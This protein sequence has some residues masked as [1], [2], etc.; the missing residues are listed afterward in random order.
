MRGAADTAI[1]WE[2]PD[3]VQRKTPV[4]I[5]VHRTPRAGSSFVVQNHGPATARRAARSRRRFTACI[6]RR[7]APGLTVVSA[8]PAKTD[9]QHWTR[10][11]LLGQAGSGRTGRLHGN[12][13][14][15]GGVSGAH[16]PP[17]REHRGVEDYHA[18]RYAAPRKLAKPMSSA[19]A[20][21][22]PVALVAR[23][24]ARGTAAA[25]PA[26]RLSSKAAVG[27]TLP[28]RPV[29]RKP[30]PARPFVPR[31]ALAGAHDR[32]SVVTLWQLD[33]AFLPPDADA[34][35]HRVVSTNLLNRTTGRLCVGRRVST[36]RLRLSVFTSSRAPRAR[37]PLDTMASQ[38]DAR[39]RRTPLRVIADSTRTPS[40][41]G[42]V[43]PTVQISFACIGRAAVRDRALAYALRRD[44][45][46]PANGA[47]RPFRV[48]AAHVVCRHVVRP[49]PRLSTRRR[50][51]H[52]VP[53][54][55]RSGRLDIDVCLWERRRGSEYR[56]RDT[57]AVCLTGRGRLRHARRRQRRTVQV[58]A[59]TTTRG[60]LHTVSPQPLHGGARVG[61]QGRH[62][63]RH[64]RDP[65][66]AA[67][68]GATCLDC[69]RL[70]SSACLGKLRHRHAR[71][72]RACF[73][74]SDHCEARR[75]TLSKRGTFFSEESVARA[76]HSLANL[77][78]RFLPCSGMP[79]R[80]SPPCSCTAAA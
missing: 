72:L 9:G 79:P 60:V 13:M 27:I 2:Y 20:S 21:V 32:P 77:T 46:L 73:R 25:R 8:R 69:H 38:E 24:V 78:R 43:L 36:R 68:E 7:I 57:L 54:A 31:E 58:D 17:E 48:L 23:P 70:R 50:T 33:G 55:R 64:R 30:L 29:V 49:H 26:A 44:F 45:G 34:A 67:G 51:P 15:C 18:L 40:H 22:A 41:D 19:V 52:T 80:T 63:R 3:T 74:H 53:C 37:L 35:V 56:V 28:A 5:V 14:A 16:N 39:I 47:L 12:Q 65:E 1:A 6:G 4:G 42:A 62:V 76:N 66:D 75:A 11:W 10:G 61:R 71:Y 59:E